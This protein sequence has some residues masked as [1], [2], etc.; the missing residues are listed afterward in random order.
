MKKKITDEHW[1]NRRKFVTSQ[2]VKEHW[3]VSD[4]WLKNARERA[5]FPFYRPNGTNVL[6]YRPE[7]IDAYIEKGRVI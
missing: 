2:Y 6:F 1:D 7:D 5:A 4:D 3:G